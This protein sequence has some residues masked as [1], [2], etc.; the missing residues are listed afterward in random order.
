MSEAGTERSGQTVQRVLVF[1][2]FDL[3]HDGH[4]YFLQEAARLGA[5][6]LVVL[7]RDEEIE[8][9]K[10]RRPA[11]SFAVR[12]AKL[13]SSPLVYDVIESDLLHGS[14]GV[15]GK[16]APQLIALGDGQEALGAV[17]KEFLHTHELDISIAQIQPINRQKLSSSRR[18]QVRKILAYSSLI[19][20]LIF[21]AASWVAGRVSAS[22]GLPAPFASHLRM[23]MLAGFFGLL[24]LRSP[25]KLRV[26]LQSLSFCAISAV[27]LVIYNLLFFYGLKFV[28]SNQAGIINAI[29]IPL[30]STAIY[31]T[32]RRQALPF[33]KILGLSLGLLSGLFLLGLAPILLSALSKAQALSLPAG[34]LHYSLF[35]FTALAWSILGIFSHKAQSQLGLI[36]YS[37][38][39]Y[40]FAS[41]FS[42]WGWYWSIPLGQ[43]AWT[44]LIIVVGIGSI[45]GTSCYFFA[46]RV[47]PSQQANVYLFLNPVFIFALSAIFLKESWDIWL[48]VGSLLAMLSILLLNLS[49]SSATKNLGRAKQ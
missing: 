34:F 14:F 21:W 9:F 43:V 39:L 29:F 1:G 40:L 30:F 48:S 22:G 27:F 5:H 16:A 6:L 45:L 36:Q 3:F 12:K 19:L 15:I 25:A 17:L 2:S 28:Q 31:Y 33:L 20:T 32:S 35:T 41:L 4:R 46:L 44:P 11:D 38:Y 42:S 13:L 37:F 23:L 49:Q 26:P 10:G 7:A 18:H 47:L 24:S 8:Y